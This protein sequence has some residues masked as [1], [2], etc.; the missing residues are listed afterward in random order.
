MLDRLAVEVV[1]LGAVAFAEQCAAPGL[2]ASAQSVPLARVV[3]VTRSSARARE[4]R[5]SG[6]DGRLDQLDQRPDRR[7]LLVVALGL[8]DRGQGR[9][10]AAEPEVQRSAEKFGDRQREPLAA[11]LSI[12]DRGSDQLRELGLATAQSSKR[13]RTV[14]D[15]GDPG[16]LGRGSQLLLIR[17]GLAQVAEKRVHTAAIGEDK[18]Q[19]GQRPGL[20]D[21]VEVPRREHRPG[22]VV[23]EIQ[24]DPAGEPEPTSLLG[25]QHRRPTGKHEAPPSGSGRPPRARR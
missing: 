21:E 23:E 19:R 24:R 1:G 6:P 10:V 7:A 9:V 13:E 18:R 12:A 25:R 4:L 3:S 2:G 16:R 22:L 17:R 15:G 14:R 5:L 20:P 11:R 8:A